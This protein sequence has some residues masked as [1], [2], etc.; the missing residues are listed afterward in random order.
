MS[1]ADPKV[2]IEKKAVLLK[3]NTILLGKISLYTIINELQKWQK[4]L[5]E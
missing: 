1:E 2:F 5:E 3:I 4:E